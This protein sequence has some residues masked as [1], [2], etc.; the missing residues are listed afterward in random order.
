MA[1]WKALTWSETVQTGKPQAR[2]VLTTLCLKCNDDFRV[3]SDAERLAG[4]CELSTRRLSDS[5]DYLEKHGFITVIRRLRP[6][7]SEAKPITLLNVPGAPHLSGTPVVLDYGGKYLYP[8]LPQE[9]HDAGIRWVAAGEEARVH[10]SHTQPVDNSAESDDQHDELSGCQHDELSGCVTRGEGVDPLE[11]QHDELSGC[12]HDAASTHGVDAASTRSQSPFEAIPSVHPETGED[13]PVDGQTEDGT[14]NEDQAI[15]LMREERAHAHLERLGPW[16]S[17]L[18]QIHDALLALLAEAS[19]QQ[20]RGLLLG[21]L[22]EAKRSITYVID[23]LTSHA[24]EVHHVTPVPSR[25]EKQQAK[26]EAGQQRQAQA[27]RRETPEE[28][29]QELGGSGA[30]IPSRFRE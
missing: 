16:K 11:S 30:Y 12:Q 27:A 6:N 24:A 29:M 22:S 28:L 19:E 7:G 10:P 25:A 2:H 18:D 17:Q 23:G 13:E 9:L 5:R 26:P 15:A 4:F 1:N 8:R 21:K 14:P 20:V 3:F